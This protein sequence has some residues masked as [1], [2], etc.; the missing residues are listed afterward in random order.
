[1]NRQA[2]QHGASAGEPVNASTSAAKTPRRTRI[3]SFRIPSHLEIAHIAMQSATANAT[4]GNANCLASDLERVIY[5]ASRAL[6]LLTSCENCGEHVRADHPS[7]YCD[8]CHKAYPDLLT[9]EQEA[10]Q[11]G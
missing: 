5:A 6:E 4:N 11:N 3:R 1:M 2:G 8:A 7:D 10:I 9:Y